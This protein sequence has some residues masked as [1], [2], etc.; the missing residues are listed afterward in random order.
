MKLQDFVKKYELHDS[1][2]E[3]IIYNRQKQELVLD[4]DLCY[5]M[6]KNYKDSEPETGMI[7]LVFE[8]VKE[9]SEMTGEVADFSILNVDVTD[10]NGV[11]ISVLD[12]ENNEFHEV[13]FNA[14]SVRVMV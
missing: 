10:D 6:Q 5:W 2:L 14:D 9:Y 3:Y 4:I 1:L 11:K 13:S 8:G 12:D 7:K